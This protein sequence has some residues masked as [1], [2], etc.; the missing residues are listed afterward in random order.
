MIK[1]QG[2]SDGMETA[3]VYLSMLEQLYDL[4]KE[5]EIDKS[6]IAETATAMIEI[7]CLGRTTR[8]SCES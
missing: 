2:T 5:D 4:W 8:Q 7:A 1:P 6:V 3:V